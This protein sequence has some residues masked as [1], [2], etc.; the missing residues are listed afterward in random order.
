MHELAVATAVPLLTA[1]DLAGMRAANERF[2]AAIAAGDVDAA[3][4]ADDAF[5][6]IPVRGARATRP[7][8]RCWSSSPRSYGGSNGCGSPRWRAA[9][10]W[11]ATP[12]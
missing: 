8:W 11:P 6:A 2:R 7:W 10:R 9:A 1:A 4:A 5:H 3:L 12:A